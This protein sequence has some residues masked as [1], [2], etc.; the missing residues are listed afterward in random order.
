MNNIN[1]RVAELR[2]VLNLSM[3]KFGNKIG[4]T[5]NSINAIEKGRNNPSEQTI[6]LICKAYNVSPLW[7]KEGIGDMFLDFPKTELDRIAQDYALDETDK[8]LIETFL[9]SSESDRKAIK[10]FLQTFAKKIE[11]KKD[12]DI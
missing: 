7:L 6:M 3:E 2:K 8:L 11:Q 4:I 1:N 10:N 9:E 12:E 5:R